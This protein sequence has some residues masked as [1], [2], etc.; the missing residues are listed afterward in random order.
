MPL[1][2]CP[3]CPEPELDRV[4]LLVRICC[5]I[6]EEKG[7]EIVGVYRVPGN[8]AAVT[9]LTEQINKNE[10]N[11]CLDDHRNVICSFSRLADFYDG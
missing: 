3:M 6:V 2:E 8:N 5:S 9:Y 1:E 10:E 4:P 11:F 7:L